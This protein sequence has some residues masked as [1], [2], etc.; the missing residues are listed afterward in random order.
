M[1]DK[2]GI[3]ECYPGLRL[4]VEWVRPKV[5]SGVGM[6]RVHEGKAIDRGLNRITEVELQEQD[7][8]SLPKFQRSAEVSEV[9]NYLG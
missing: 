7:F 6:I 8:G 5:E 9:P 4:R 1:E 3:T 2:G